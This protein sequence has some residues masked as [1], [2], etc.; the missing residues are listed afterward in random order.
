VTVEASA[1]R[2]C[3]GYDPAIAPTNTKGVCVV[4]A[5][6]AGH[7]VC[8]RRCDRAAPVPVPD[9]GRRASRAA[10]CAVVDAAVLEFVMQSVSA[11]RNS[12]SCYF[13]LSVRRVTK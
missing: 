3:H 2:E 4:V 9:A 7:A 1:R 12:R 13:S 6:S 10:Y 8:Q 5:K 11:P